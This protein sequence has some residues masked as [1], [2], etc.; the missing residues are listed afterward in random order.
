MKQRS[1]ILAVV[2]MTAACNRPAAD[3]AVCA[4]P[5]PLAERAASDQRAIALARPR[6]TPSD[7][8]AV[9]RASADS[10][11]QR[12]AYRLRGSDAD[13]GVVKTAVLGA[14]D[15]EL[16]MLTEVAAALPDSTERPIAEWSER[17]A[18]FYTVQTR[19]GGCRGPAA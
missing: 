14:C 17:R 18:I 1:M 15:A 3:P 4:G 13:L 6:L 5:P 19:A 2:A 11:L 10:C 12:W 16:A 9:E 8:V 7:R